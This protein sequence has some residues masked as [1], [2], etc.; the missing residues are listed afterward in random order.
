MEAFG[1]YLLKSVVWLSSFALIFFL[2]LRNER[3]FSL[4]RIFL[5]AGIIS[6]FVFPLLTVHYS[7]N[8]PVPVRVQSG[9]PV[10]TVIQAGNNNSQLDGRM[11]LFALYISGVLFVTSLI[12]IKSRSILQTIKKADI[13][14]SN[15][16][17]L[18]RTPDYA[19]A[20]SF[21]SYV[22]VNPSVTDI[23][24]REIVNHEMAHIRQKHWIDLV[25]VEL[26]CV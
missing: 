13:T 18:I 23:E 19:S 3:F 8:I 12:V 5:V 7:V 1:L 21:F 15:P 22:F 14:I 6:S 16:V 17:K 26:L 20:F 11:L 9:D 24:T 10:M 2:F 25:L 4:N